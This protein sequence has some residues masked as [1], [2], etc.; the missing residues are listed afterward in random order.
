MASLLIVLFFSVTGITL[1]HPDWTFGQP[2]V[3]ETVTG[4]LPEGAVTASGPDL[5]AVSEYLRAEQGVR[6]TVTDAGR[7]GDQAS[8]SYRAPGYAADVLVR[9]ADSSYTLTTNSSGF[10]AVMNDLHKGRNTSTLWRWVIDITAGLLVVMSVTGIVL[11]TTI[12]R[13]R[14]TAFWLA[15]VGS[16]VAVVLIWVSI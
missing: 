12:R 9:T 10:V 7:S 11:Q 1:N 15:T 14:R 6:G 13:R 2:P 8:I 16:L 5:L 3:S 4:S